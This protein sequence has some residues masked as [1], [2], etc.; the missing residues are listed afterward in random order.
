V[1]IPTPTFPGQENGRRMEKWREEKE[2]GRDRKG[3]ELRERKRKVG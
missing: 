3:R 1:V 2:Y